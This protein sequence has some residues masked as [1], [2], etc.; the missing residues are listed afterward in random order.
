[1]PDVLIIG[2][3]GF[4]GRNLSTQLLD[5]DFNV[6]NFGRL[7]TCPDELK[8]HRA[9]T[10]IPG[11]FSKTGELYPLLETRT[12]TCVLHLVSTL[13]PGSG[14]EEFVAG[15]EVNIDAGIRL[16]KKMCATG[17]NRLLFFSSGGTIYG[18]NQQK[19]ND[20]DSPTSPINYYGY[21]KLIFEDFIRLYH[22][23]H[24]LN[25]IIVRPSNPYGK[26]QNQDKK[27]GLIGVTLTKILKNEP[28]EIWGDGEITRDYIYISDLCSA[29]CKL[30]V[31]PTWNHI[32]NISSG[33]GHSVN[34][35]VEE[36]RNVTGRQF[37]VNYLP[38]RAVD[39]PVN[40]LNSDKIRKQT[41]W[42]PE[43]SLHEGIAR[44]WTE[45]Q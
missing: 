22:L 13:L 39:I 31:A 30:L 4:I 43:I 41:G 1:M 29:I 45:L 33:K 34:R 20:E 37:K 9:Y 8:T 35:I 19:V 15:H 38:G 24:K 28:I 11:D 44:L 2:G 25:Y 23:T 36:I 17:N 18:N 27:Q 10:F 3:S 6:F 32:Y 7:G 16:I 12:F 40:I 26:G 21:S 42:K 5:A 14:Y